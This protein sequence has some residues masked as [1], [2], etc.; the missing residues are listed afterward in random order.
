MQVVCGVMIQ[1]SLST[2]VEAVGEDLYEVRNHLFN[3]LTYTVFKE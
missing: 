3:K 1:P 2:V